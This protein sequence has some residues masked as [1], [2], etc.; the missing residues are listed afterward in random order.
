MKT[1]T[2]FGLVFIQF[3][4]FHALANNVGN[5]QAQVHEENAKISEEAKERNINTA[6]AQGI[7]AVSCLYPC[8]YEVSRGI[9][10]LGSGLATVYEISQNEEF[11]DSIGSVIGTGV[12]VLGGSTISLL[13]N[14]V[15]SSCVVAGIH[16]VVG[17]IKV[18]N[19][20]E[21]DKAADEARDKANEF[22]DRG[23]QGTPTVTPTITADNENP[24]LGNA[25]PRLTLGSSPGAPAGGNNPELTTSCSGARREGDAT[26]FLNCLA[27]RG[28][29]AG[30]VDSNFPN[31]FKDLTGLDLGKF[32]A[33]LNDNATLGDVVAGGLGPKFKD[34]VGLKKRIDDLVNDRKRLEELN[35]IINTGGVT[36]AANSAAPG[37][38]DTSDERKKIDPA[39][40]FGGKKKDK[41]AETKMETFGAGK[42]E[43]TDP[44][45]IMSDRSRS[46]FERIS[47]AYV[48]AASADRIE[49]RS[50]ELYYNQ[51]MS[52]QPAGS[53]VLM[54]R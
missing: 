35:K 16:I 26:Q 20:I 23:N 53:S 36:L 13:G 11:M 33:S 29:L 18:Y 15:N 37:K 1:L 24:R 21:A 32:I 52:R 45:A 9:C 14:N 49:K 47:T 31:Q 25:P 42:K 48:K 3:T 38:S 19:A 50:Y 39:S 27:A 46:L 44:E 41:K 7:A 40:L 6:I 28:E 12:A 43:E 51:L 54:K 30:T 22:R 34:A 10:I 5:I 4:S 17:G 2:L 8:I